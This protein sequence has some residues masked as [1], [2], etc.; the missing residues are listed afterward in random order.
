MGRPLKAHP[1]EL[2]D[3]SEKL[4][5]A[6]ASAGMGSRRD[7]EQLIADGRVTIN[8]QVAKVGDR[9]KAGDLV[10]VNGKVIRMGWKKQTPR[11]LIYH[12]LDGEIV[13]RDDPEGRPSVF[14]SLPQVRSGRWISIGRLDFNTEGLLIFT[15][16]GELANH[17]THP[18]Y[19]VEREYAVRLIGALDAVQMNSLLTGVELDDGIAKVDAIVPAGGE[20]VNQW[21]HLIIKEGRNREVRRL[22]EHLGLTVSRLIRVRFGPIAMPSRLK[23]GMKEELPEEEVE[24]LLRW[25][26]MAKGAA[27][28]RKSE[29][30]GEAK[31]TEAKRPEAKHT[32]A[33]RPEAKRLEAKHPEAAPAKVGHPFRRRLNSKGER[34]Q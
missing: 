24:A 6:L 15:T 7:M 8:S 3:H 31:H 11:V 28:Q 10:K 30:S 32:E 5:K 4:H 14:D 29:E 2:E 25:C 13:S 17:L 21:Y 22:M 34:Q 23:R 19:E 27:E 9:V 16:D 18:R 20:G 33:K 12:K 1:E 26:G